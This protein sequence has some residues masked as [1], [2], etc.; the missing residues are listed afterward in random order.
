MWIFGIR[1]IITNDPP[2]EPTCAR[3]VV[4]NH[5]TPIDVLMVLKYLS[6][7]ILSRADL[8][9]WPILGWAARKAQ[10]IF[11]ERD[12]KDSR[13]AAVKAIHNRLATGGVAMVFPE[14]TTFGGDEVRPF[15]PGSFSAT[16]GLH[17]EIATVGLV[18]PPG[19]EFVEK[20][21]ISH[22]RNIAARPKIVVAVS[23]GE[24]RQAWDNPEDMAKWAQSEVQQLVQKAREKW[25]AH[26]LRGQPS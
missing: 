11:V 1:T 20:D 25:N 16:T 7:A 23:F 5:R 26:N 13:S 21:F 9:H 22:L 12:Q 14:G 15:R 10:T 4:C 6:G 8:A 19:T 18:Y 3:L 24:P 2:K 17:A